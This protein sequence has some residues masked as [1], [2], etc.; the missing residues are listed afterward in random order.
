MECV[1]PISQCE[2]KYG[3]PV[4]LDVVQF[5]PGL[6]GGMAGLSGGNLRMRKRVGPMPELMQE[7][8]NVLES[9]GTLIGTLIRE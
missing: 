5:C 9:L 3:Y 1:D 7:P 4:A 8:F 6:H 2:S